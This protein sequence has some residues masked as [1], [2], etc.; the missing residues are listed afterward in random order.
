LAFRILD[1]IGKDHSRDVAR[2]GSMFDLVK[3]LLSTR[4]LAEAPRQLLDAAEAERFAVPSL[5]PARCDACTKCAA[6]C[7]TGV[8]QFAEKDGAKSLL[9]R[10]DKCIRCDLC[11]EACPPAALE[12]GF[13]LPPA[14]RAIAAFRQSYQW[15]NGMFVLQEPAE[16]ELAP[17][18]D[19]GEPGKLE[20]LRL[21]ARSFAFRELD[22]GSCNACEVEVNMLSS[23]RYDVERFG[24]GA[25]ASP[26][27]SDGVVLTGPVCRNMKTAC[28]RTLQAIPE[29]KLAIALGSCAIS[30]GIYEGSYATS[31]GAAAVTRVDVYVPGC[32][33]APS[34]IIYGLLLAM[35]SQALPL[36]LADR[37]SRPAAISSGRD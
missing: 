2:G 36:D 3:K 5:L 22:S 8:F 6:A 11:L 32:P 23:P 9:V 35:R 17:D 19:V 30:G 37:P 21:F 29:P 27:F 14:S 24:I 12:Y 15:S 13:R 33:P 20:A 4:N 31:D 34:A 7:P 28:L 18:V 10:G 1:A 16:E 26:R 25:T